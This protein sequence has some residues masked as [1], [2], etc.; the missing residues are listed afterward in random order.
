MSNRSSLYLIVMRGSSIGS[1]CVLAMLTVGLYAQSSS[2]TGTIVKSTPAPPIE[3]LHYNV[4]WRL[5]PAGT[6]VVSMKPNPPGT[7]QG[8]TANVKLT[9]SGLLDKLFRVNDVYRAEY[10]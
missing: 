9:S 2:S 6:A 8:Y 4:D 5:I 3:T 1:R 7:N 10:E